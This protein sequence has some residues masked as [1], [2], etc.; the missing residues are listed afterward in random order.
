[1]KV[2]RGGRGL[3]D[4][5]GERFLR[6]WGLESDWKAVGEFELSFEVGNENRMKL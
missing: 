3:E 6:G 4:G 2:W 1:M 5:C